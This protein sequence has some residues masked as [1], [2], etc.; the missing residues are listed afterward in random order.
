MIYEQIYFQTT[1]RANH[2][3]DFVR[4][5]RDL[6]SFRHKKIALATDIH[7]LT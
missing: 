1:N 2:A 6:L 5:S 4:K 3:D 7:E